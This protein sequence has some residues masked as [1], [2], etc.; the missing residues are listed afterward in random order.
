MSPKRIAAFVLIL[1]IAGTFV[2]MIVSL[3]TGNNN[4]FFILGGVLVG[5]V[6]LALFVLKLFRR[7]STPE[8]KD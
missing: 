6:I 5:L 4:L 8:E 7:D 2:G 1:V 3:L